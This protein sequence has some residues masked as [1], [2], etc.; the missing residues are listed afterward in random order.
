MK[1]RRPVVSEE[2]IEILRKVEAFRKLAYPL[3][4]WQHEAIRQVVASF[5]ADDESEF[6][7]PTE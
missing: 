7:A 6:E 3:T 2:T 4:Y 1:F 5:D